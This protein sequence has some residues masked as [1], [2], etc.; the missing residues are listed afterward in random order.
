VKLTFL[1]HTPVQLPVPLWAGPEP[2]HIASS[3]TDL[4]AFGV[5]SPQEAPANSAL[6]RALVGTG[7]ELVAVPRT[8]LPLEDGIGALLR[9][10]DHAAQA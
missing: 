3:A 10:A 6:I 7:A 1:D 9:Y 5:R 8:T 4:E 2:T